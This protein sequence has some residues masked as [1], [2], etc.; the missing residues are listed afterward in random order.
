MF[1]P[2]IYLTQ[3]ATTYS[4]GLNEGFS[5][6]SPGVRGALLDG[7]GLPGIPVSAPLA[8][9]LSLSALWR[10]EGL[11]GIRR[12]A[13]VFG[14]QLSKLG[15]GRDDLSGHPQASDTMVPGSVVCDQRE[16][17]RER[18]GP[19]TGAGTEELQDGLDVATQIATRYGSPGAGPADGPGGGG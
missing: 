19:A 15:D 16:E 5:A 9:W 8:G 11:A 18:P 13:T 1:K 7:G 17:R 6:G 12:F 4:M 3:V 14:L 2:D 10:A